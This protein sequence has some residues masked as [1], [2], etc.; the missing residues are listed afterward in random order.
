M[1]SQKPWI[2]LGLPAHPSQ[3]FALFSY[4][5]LFPFPVFLVFY[6]FFFYFKP[7]EKFKEQYNEHSF[8]PTTITYC[9][10]GFCVPTISLFIHKNLYVKISSDIMALQS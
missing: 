6:F 2:E 7:K 3:I 5:E 4:V 9:H 10:R 1:S 8:Y